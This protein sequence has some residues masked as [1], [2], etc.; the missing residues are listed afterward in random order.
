MDNKRKSTFKV[1]SNSK[2]SSSS[3][4]AEL[5]GTQTIIS[6]PTQSKKNNR[7]NEITH[8]SDATTNTTLHNAIRK[9]NKKDPTTKKKALEELIHDINKANVEEIVTIL[10]LWTKT[11]IEL[12]Y[13][14]IHNIR[15]LTQEVHNI[16]VSKCKR[17][18]APYLKELVPVWICSQ[19]DNYVPAANIARS[20]FFNIFNAKTNRVK[21]V[22]LH[23]QSEI[24]EYVFNNISEPSD[25]RNGTDIYVCYNK[26]YGSL[27]VL[28]FFV[29]QTKPADLSSNSHIIIRSLMENKSF[30]KWGRND[31]KLTRRA[32]F[33]AI[34]N[35]ILNTSLSAIIFEW[36]KNIIDICFTGI[37]ENDR[38]LSLR[39]WQCILL[40]QSTYDDWYKFLDFNSAVEARLTN[41]LQNNFF[42]NYE[43]TCPKMLPFCTA[44][45]F[46]STSDFDWYIFMDKFLENFKNIFCSENF[47]ANETDYK[48]VFTSYFDCLN[49]VLNKMNS[50]DISLEEK[51]QNTIELLHKNIIDPTKWLIR[52][53]RSNICKLFFEH[54]LQMLADTKIE[55]EHNQ[56]IRAYLLKDFWISIFELITSLITDQEHYPEVIIDIFQNLV[57]FGE[58]GFST[59]LDTLQTDVLME[60]RNENQLTNLASELVNHCLKRIASK[61]GESCLKHLLLFMDMF[62]DTKFNINITNNFDVTKS[63]NIFID[64]IPTA[65]ENLYV[66]IAEIIFKFINFL[67]GDQQYDFIN[68]ALIFVSSKDMRILIIERILLQPLKIGKRKYMLLSSPDVRTIITDL[69]RE[70][71]FEKSE[72]KINWLQTLFL[73]NDSGNFFISSTTVDEVITI[74]FAPFEEDNNN[75]LVELC[76]NIIS[77]VLPKIFSCR[78]VFNKTKTK[79]FTKLFSFLILHSENNLLKVETFFQLSKCWESML[80]DEYIVNEVTVLHC[81]SNLRTMN[82][83]TLVKTSKCADLII[84]FIFRTTTKYTTTKMKNI[85]QNNLINMFITTKDVSALHEQFKNYVLFMEAVNGMSTKQ[86][87]HYKCFEVQNIVTILQRSL[88]NIYIFKR[89]QDSNEMDIINCNLYHELLNC[90]ICTS[91][92]ESVLKIKP[93]VGA[94]LKVWIE[95]LQNQLKYLI[96]NESILSEKVHDILLRNAIEANEISYFRSLHILILHHRYLPFEENASIVFN[97]ELFKH[98][99]AQGALLAYI[100]FLQYQTPRLNY[101]S[102]TVSNVFDC[103]KSTDIWIKCAA[104]RCL[105]INYF[106]CD[107]GRTGDNIII[108]QLLEYVRTINEGLFI[109]FK[110]DLNEQG[111]SAVIELIEYI[112]LLTEILKKMPWCLGAKDWDNIIIG[113]GSWVPNVHKSIENIVNPKMA[114]FVINVCKL[115]SAF[116]EF[117]KVEKDRSS[118]NMLQN[119][120]DE[121]ESLFSK[122]AICNIFESFYGLLHLQEKFTTE[123]FMP[124]FS[125]LKRVILLSDVDVIYIFCKNSRTISKKNVFNI[126][127]KNFANSNIFVQRTCY[128]ILRE[129][130]HAYVVDDIKSV[131][132]LN[133]DSSLGVQSQH[134]L[135]LFEEALTSQLTFVNKYISE[136]S[137]KISEID[138]FEPID[139][140]TVFSYFLM[141]D[142]IIHTCVKSPLNVRNI[143]T[144][145][146][147]ESRFFEK[148]LL[149]VIR[150]MPIEVLKNHDSKFLSGEIFNR[151]SWKQL[152]DENLTLERYA[153]HLYT[154]VLKKLPAVVRKWWSV[155]PSRQ[156]AFVDKLTTNYVSPLICEEELKSIGANKERHENMQ[157]A[158]HYST[159]EV[160]ATYFIDDVRTELTI[161]LPSNYPLGPIKVDCGKS[162]GGRLSSRTDGMQLALFLM[163]QNGTIIDG[164]ALWKNNLDKKFEGVE[165]CYV[166]YTVIN[167]DTYQLPK[168]TCKTCKKKFH[169]S[170]LYKWFTTSSK[171]TCPICRNV[172]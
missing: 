45:M 11:Y 36:K 172:F 129:L 84:R 120:V 144:S 39:M 53:N 73:Q 113:L 85:I 52:A 64:L 145:W 135:K 95:E 74:I 81:I 155:S 160:I 110:V 98:C 147:Y 21:E 32:W 27:E 42:N 159:R 34:Q 24:L 164:L 61:E 149:F 166:C 154:E 119:M 128:H 130:T 106:N 143:Y 79:A 105:V 71:L 9:L 156:K 58:G 22:C 86:E 122:D 60:T 69:T 4:S 89:L 43:N 117:I 161:T 115:F 171:S 54:T 132:S 99:I 139:R 1:K 37:N 112:R 17:M 141:W 92:A 167:Q 131:H 142:C 137:F 157:V 50:L 41:L 97:E 91:A 65:T 6:F 136:F 83:L 169:G 82:A 14:P 40:V 134:Y 114:L 31:N 158:V 124:L 51:Q 7:S 146:L 87:V 72:E 59:K 19:F 46:V 121:W 2:P 96:Q 13:D 35:M 140:E 126:L 3:R 18:I 25:N 16:L 56:Q 88:L 70:A 90:I 153:C 66:D 68:N 162:I 80:C 152:N 30:W 94:A 165:E 57:K 125:E 5:L 33:K 75:E 163:H 28:S 26:V 102:I 77:K 63:L 10:P 116:L 111:Y 62:S 109:N 101:R 48:V 8:F 93:E 104:L 168:L 108:K 118:T 133:E 29:E 47:N 123:Y 103:A 170:C 38:M 151:L 148:F 76:G 100:N 127:L 20:S 44:L 23:C 15:E 138:E 107:E 67:D 49:L 150:A 78:S 12:A 55:S